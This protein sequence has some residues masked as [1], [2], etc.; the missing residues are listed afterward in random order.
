MSKYHRL[1]NHGILELE[2]LHRA[3]QEATNQIADEPP[4]L[5]NCLRHCE[6]HDALYPS[7]DH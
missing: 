4:L 2:Q 3:A 1:A 5:I 6:L 7:G